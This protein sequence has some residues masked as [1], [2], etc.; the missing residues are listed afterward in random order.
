MGFL[1]SFTGDT[2]VRI[3]QVRAFPSSTDDG[4]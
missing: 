3:K 1:L 2:S 4:F